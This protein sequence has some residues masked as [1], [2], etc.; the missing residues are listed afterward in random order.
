M[1]EQFQRECEILSQQIKRFIQQHEKEVDGKL[2]TDL[3]VVR[4]QLKQK[5]L[6]KK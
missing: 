1:N 2:L 6:S 5:C 3:K 4:K